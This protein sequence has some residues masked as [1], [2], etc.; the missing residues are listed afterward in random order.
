MGTGIHAHRTR[1]GRLMAPG[2]IIAELRFRGTDIE[3][4]VVTFAPGLSVVAGP[5]N[6]GKTLIRAAS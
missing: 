6:T 4:A 5:S 2:F 3:D 1:M